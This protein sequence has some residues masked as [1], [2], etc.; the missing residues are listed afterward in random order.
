MA[1][2]VDEI[3][4]DR[5]RIN[6]ELDRG[7]MASVYRAWDTRLDLPV[8]VKEML[9][10]PRLG[11]KA[12][13]Q[14][15]RQFK[16]EAQVLARL[17][18]PSLVRV[19][20]F[21]SHHDSEYLVMNFVEG[22]SLA[23]LVDRVGAL[24]EAQ[25]L[26]WADQLLSALAYC[27]SQGVIHRDVKSHNVIIRPDG[28]AVLVDFGLV[29][30]WDPNDPYTKTVMRGMGTPAFAPP[31]Q[32]EADAEHTDERSD[33]YSMGATLYHAL[34]GRLPPTSVL[35]TATPEKFVSLRSTV[36]EV[37]QQ[38]ETVVM[39]AMELARSKRWQSTDEM[40]EALKA[41]ELSIVGRQRSPS[42]AVPLW[43]GSTVVIPEGRL[44]V[45]GQRKR[46]PMWIGALS[47]LTLLLVAVGLMIGLGGKGGRSTP[48]P[49]PERTA[50]VSTPA[51]LA[52]TDT[53]THLPV[54]TPVLMP[55]PTPTVTAT[56]QPTDT[57]SPMPTPTVTAMPSLTHSPTPTATPTPTPTLIIHVL[58]EGEN[59]WTVAR[60]YGVSVEAL[61]AANGITDPGTLQIGQELII[62]R[63]GKAPATPTSTATP[64][65]TPTPTLIIHVLKA[66]ENPWTVAQLYGISVEALLAANGITDPITLQIGQELIIPR[67]GKVPTPTVKPTVALPQL[68]RAPKLL[69]PYSN[70]VFGFDQQQSINLSWVS[71]SLAEDHWYEVQLRLE[72]DEELRGHYWTKENWWDMGPEYYHPGDYYWRVIIVQGKE[73]NVVGAVS[74]PSETW[75]F[76]W[77]PVAPTT[78]PRPEPTKTPT[79]TYTPTPT[80]T[81]TLTPTPTPTL[82]PASSVEQPHGFIGMLSHLGHTQCVLNPSSGFRHR[83]RADAIG[84]HT[85]APGVLATLCG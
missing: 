57:P 54:S 44:A 41:A 5:Y 21:F 49:S 26:N 84:L 76:Q 15:R 30:L 28:Q 42:S 63:E 69:D 39:K 33:I 4:L 40:A 12:L 13:T 19:T 50:T 81:P 25:V 37:S 72:E 74:P 34:S 14:L 16:R 27:H 73:D 45:K 77:M 80:P 23:D 58:K 22:E 65:P 32:F 83:Y 20:D 62:P 68:Y 52:G 7:G 24:P 10:Q 59:P 51:I 43:E 47:I 60:L 56:L 82:R 9:P 17:D 1:L 8:A 3:L 11:P 31:E 85:R 36:P 2:A 71:I 55:S 78:M 70:Q 79:L 35:R 67:E 38:T 48:M 46:V 64:T 18:H 75:Y 53:A 6:A 61:L 66:G 29:K